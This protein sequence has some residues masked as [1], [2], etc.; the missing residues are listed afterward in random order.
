MIYH[1]VKETAG[2]PV[3]RLGLALLD[4]QNPRKVLARASDWCFGPE[5][6]YEQ[7]GLV[8]NVVFTCGAL[9]RG[10]DVWMYYGAADTVIG[11][12]TA[13]LSTLVDFVYEHD[14]LCVIGREKG[15]VV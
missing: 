5:V 15:M 4:L 6:N 2:H 10:D 13:K 14:Y 1:G 7:Y 3:Y 9:L 11:L 8:P 12:A